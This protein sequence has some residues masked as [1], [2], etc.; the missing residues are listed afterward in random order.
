[1]NNKITERVRK[2]KGISIFALVLLLFMFGLSFLAVGNA[3]ADICEN[4]N[5]PA[6][7]LP[8]TDLCRIWT[9]GVSPAHQGPFVPCS[10][11]EVN[12]PVDSC[13]INGVG[14]SVQCKKNDDCKKHDDCDDDC[15]DDDDDCKGK[16][17]GSLCRKI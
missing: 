4:L 11:Q 5:V 15:D 1:M 9:P 14:N 12:V 10:C 8:P 7:H 3:Q 13:L 17:S 6:S 2:T 16:K